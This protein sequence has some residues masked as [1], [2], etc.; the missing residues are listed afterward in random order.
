MYWME[1]AARFEEPSSPGWDSLTNVASL[2][3]GS[4]E[5]EAVRTLDKCRQTATEA[6]SCLLVTA[7]N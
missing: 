2:V 5:A 4:G 1:V 7:E 3:V 6:K